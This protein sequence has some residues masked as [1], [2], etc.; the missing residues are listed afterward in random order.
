MRLVAITLHG[1]KRF[2]DST[3]INVDGP[4]V[5]VVGP[6][7]AG[8]TSLLKGI[9]HLQG[10]GR[11][12]PGE[13]TRGRKPEGEVIAARFLIDKE[14]HNLIGDIPGAE[15]L[16]WYVLYKGP[17][18]KLKHYVEPTVKRNIKPRQAV[19][20]DLVRAANHTLLNESKAPHPFA[21]D[22]ARMAEVLDTTKDSLTKKT[23]HQIGV[24]AERL[25]EISL[26]AGAPKYISHLPK[27]LQ[28]LAELEGTRDPTNHVLSVLE[29]R[30]PKFVAFGRPERDLRSDYDLS[31]VATSPPPALANLTRLADLDLQ[32]LR[33]AQKAKNYARAEKLLEDANN[34]LRTRFEDAWKQS[35][36]Y[37]RLRTDDLVL[38]IFVAAADGYTDITERSDGLLAFIALLTFSALHDEGQPIILLVDEA[39][40]HLHYDAQ[41]ELVRVFS[42]QKAAEKVIYTTHSAGCLP[43]DLG[44]V[45]FVSAH[46]D[47]T[48]SITN[49]Y[50]AEGPGLSPLLVGMGATVLA[51]TPARRAVLAEGGVD[52]ILLPALFRAVK[53]KDE[54]EF[55]VVPGLSEVR[56][57]DVP[58]LDLDAAAVAYYV[59][60]DSGGAKIKRKLTANG[61][62]EDRIVVLGGAG[63][64]VTLE[65]LV[66]AEL[67]AAAVTAVLKR[68]DSAAPSFPKS[69]L[70]TRERA[71]AVHDWCKRKNQREPNKAVVAYEVLELQ[72]K[73]ERPLVEKG[74]IA[75]VRQAYEGLAR[76]LHLDP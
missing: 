64:K 5:A 72:G 9:E 13:L 7:E 58:R 75:L 32:E 73:Q 11:F 54:L 53:G 69:S 34:T 71:K 47:G 30:C 31:E 29:K 38:R 28:E 48:S 55:Q 60:G 33:N 2:A 45:R 37:L 65:D 42:T 12:R 67:Y 15:K 16:R 76:L 35:G 44:R 4:V 49:A 56:P 36:V 1:Y 19:Q 40:N 17:N 21:E 59:D 23:V 51:F 22:A 20:A 24:T 62:P 52:S 74:R 14:D 10:G 68:G 43:N 3:T 63:S 66:D 39:E 6:N 70:P 50:W 46:E 27:R 61:V 18:G 25:A 41:A 57:S 26:P 8:K